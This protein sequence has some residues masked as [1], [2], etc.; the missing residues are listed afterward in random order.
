MRT[1]NTSTDKGFS[2]I[3]L[4]GIFSQKW[5]DKLFMPQYFSPEN[6]VIFLFANLLWLYI[7]VEDENK[8]PLNLTMVGNHL[9]QLTSQQSINFRHCFPRKVFLCVPSLLKI[10]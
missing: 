3:R 10:L 9:Y 1:L 4:V 6:G 2:L 5:L 7:D 8:D